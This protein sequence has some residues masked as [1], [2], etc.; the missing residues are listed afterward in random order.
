MLALT[1]LIKMAIC[2][3]DSVWRILCDHFGSDAREIVKI[4]S[5]DSLD[6]CGEYRATHCGVNV[7]DEVSIGFGSNN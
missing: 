7:G 1:S 6:E 3:C 2:G 4:S 5:R